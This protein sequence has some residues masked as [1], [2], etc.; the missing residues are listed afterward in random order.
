[1]EG[2]IARSPFSGLNFLFGDGERLYAY[3]LGIFELHWLHRPGQLLVA[4]ER[5][6]DEPWHSV[7]QDVLLTLDPDD[8]EEPHAERLVGDT[9]VE[10]ADIVKFEEGSGLRG[11]E[12]GRFAEE[13]AA[14]MRR[15]R[16]RQGPLALLLNPA[17]SGGTARATRC[18]PCR[19][20][21][22]ASAR[23][24]AMVE[25]AQHRA[26]RA[27]RRC[28]RPPTGE[29]VV[30]IGR[31][32][33]GGRAGRRAPRHRRARSAIIPGGRGND[34]ARV[35]GIPRD[36]AEAARLA[37]EGEERLVDVGR[38]GRQAVRRHRE[39]GL[40]LDANR[41][42]NEAQARASGNLVYLYAGLRALA[43][44]KPANFTVTVDGERHEVTG[45]T[46]A[47][48]NSKAYGGGMYAGPARRAR[49]RPARRD[50]RAQAQSKLRFL[51][52]HAEGVQGRPRG[53]SRHP[54]ADAATE[55]EVDADRPFTIYADGDPIADLPATIAVH[56]ADAARHRPR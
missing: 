52:A 17:A 49:R 38:G 11:E 34:F 35:L 28:W 14:R 40:R 27:R 54:L 20:S 26:R 22:T 56:A 32:R 9:W 1:M 3:R 42:A 51:R 8:V 25:H 21:S 2:V 33:P 55:I 43:A 6:T 4:T 15:R 10:R 53:R 24:T 39:L 41:I 47:V 31:R 44:W 48:A 5:I 29:T 16:V 50:A 12:R 13:R 37:V 30:A 23:P 7:A 19:R 46:V 36:P 18:R 45:Y